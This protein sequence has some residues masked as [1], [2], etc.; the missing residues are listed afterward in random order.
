MKSKILFSVFCIVMLVCTI[1]GAMALEQ[2]PR[3]GITNQESNWLSGTKSTTGYT[4]W[5]DIGVSDTMPLVA[6]LD[7]S[8]ANEVIESRSN[9]VKIF[10]SD[11]TLITSK[12]IS[13]LGNRQV[14]VFNSAH[15]V[16]GK[17]LYLL[18]SGNAQEW[19]FNG[20]NLTHYQ[21]VTAGGTV[22]INDTTGL[23]MMTYGSEHIYGAYNAEV[24]GANVIAIVDFT[25][26]GY[27]D[28]V[29]QDAT[30]NIG[31]PAVG[32]PY[33]DGRLYWMFP[34]SNDTA[35]GVALVDIYGDQAHIEAT[36]LGHTLPLKNPPMFVSRGSGNPDDILLPYNG[37]QHGINSDMQ[38][39]NF[40]YMDTTGY[41]YTTSFGTVNEYEIMGS[42]N[43]GSYAV[44]TP[45][46]LGTGGDIC[47][48]FGW[49]AYTNYLSFE[50]GTLIKCMNPTTLALTYNSTINN[51]ITVG[52]IITYPSRLTATDMNGDG[53][54]DFFLSTEFESGSVGEKC[55]FTGNS[56]PLSC[57]DLAGKDNWIYGVDINN[58]GYR[59]IIE[60]DLTNNLLRIHL[61]NGTAP[62]ATTCSDTDSGSYPT[63]NYYLQGTMTAT[64]ISPRQDYCS[65]NTVYEF[66]CDSPTTYHSLT[67][68]AH[69][70][71]SEGKI[72][73][74]GACVNP[75]ANNSQRFYRDDFDNSFHN[76]T[77][78]DSQY[79]NISYNTTFQ[80]F[81]GY[82]KVSGTTG[83]FLEF[84]NIDNSKTGDVGY[85]KTQY[86][87]QAIDGSNDALV[88][89]TRDSSDTCGARYECIKAGSPT[90][91]TC[92]LW[93][94]GGWVTPTFSSGGGLHT[95]QV[96]FRRETS[97][98]LYTLYY[99]GAGAGS[100]QE[101]ASQCPVIGTPEMIEFG[102]LNTGSSTGFDAN[103]YYVEYSITSQS[104]AVSCTDTDGGIVYE[105]YGTVTYVNT[106]GTVVYNDQCTGV[107]QLKEY[108]CDANNRPVVNYKPCDCVSGRCV[109]YGVC[110]DSDYAGSYPTIQ[111]FTYGEINTSDG[112]HFA[113]VCVPGNSVLEYYCN[114]PNDMNSVGSTTIHCQPGYTCNGGACV[115]QTTCTT[116]PPTYDYPVRW[117]E[118]FDYTDP[119]TAHGWT[120]YP[121]IPG[122]SSYRWNECNRLYYDRSKS[123]DE[124]DY[125]TQAISDNFTYQFSLKPMS[126]ST[127]VDY[128]PYQAPVYVYLKDSTGAEALTLHF[129]DNGY[130]EYTDGNGVTR[131]ITKWGDWSQAMG[132]DY[133]IVMFPSDHKFNFYYTESTSSI[134]YTQGCANCTYNPTAGAIAKFG[135][136]P[137]FTEPTYGFFL[138]T[139]KV[140]IGDTT[141]V[142]LK[143]E[144]PSSDRNCLFY[145]TFSYTDAT[146]NHG[147]YNYITTPTNGYVTLPFD[148]M[149]NFD[150]VITPYSWGSGDGI[151]TYQ[152]NAQFN[153]PVPSD[154][155]IA[156]YAKDSTGSTVLLTSWSDMVYEPF[157][158]PTYRSISAYPWGAW[159]TYSFVINTNKNT[160]SFYID[161]QVKVSNHPLL[162]VSNDI[163]IVGFQV[164]TAGRQMLINSVRVEQGQTFVDGVT[165][166][167]GTGDNG[168]N[169]DYL[170][171]CWS[172]NGT[173]DW[174]CCTADEQASKSMFCPIRVT[175][176]GWLAQ[177]ASFAIG[178]IL[179]VIVLAVILVIFIP[180]L[181]PRPGN[182]GGR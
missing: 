6:D 132:Y 8:G 124:I 152:F 49:F 86:A 63:L 112:H 84:S 162:F 174:S 89:G 71:A 55:I 13:G 142:G 88:M 69:D 147:W 121:F 154:A 27:N 125:A 1:A 82:M 115:P 10:Q 126:F 46:Q 92:G 53:Y 135:F 164:N 137:D 39:I 179:I 37:V 118:T 169:P 45:V 153:K 128:D 60:S 129:A 58:D 31:T 151:V 108:S 54:A 159:D 76:T 40:V 117:Y 72:C 14:T 50:S 19:C 32:N 98:N 116:I 173:Y 107:F 38:T 5:T 56:N 15:C 24:N 160:Y 178:N 28:Y 100:Y 166:S 171:Q 105:T 122:L 61:T 68:T 81:N 161:G 23:G 22:Y 130:I 176:V 167:S 20:V 30:Q 43:A 79:I 66:Y 4:T 87:L 181:V 94:N 11:G 44:S 48:A 36:G 83:S 157:G 114:D 96:S 144:C 146:L 102:R 73:S 65:G 41:I 150:H 33:N 133:I 91:F 52:T 148:S 26:G 77:I 120:G 141:A 51:A 170:R 42:P 104:V 127:D 156:I 25:T 109:D 177:L 172:N 158:L 113:D 143:S 85:V 29:V 99:D 64:G 18:T 78:W 74:S 123:G 136:K 34:Y 62:P 110:S 35:C 149:S 111:P 101:N 3:Y 57:T 119:I 163:G 103:F 93:A 134:D 175:V 17:A 75:P 138:D 9:V 140:T 155:E 131:Q 2:V 168:V 47:Y 165:G 95:A 182:N 21:D 7:G 139:L 145:D 59:D 16:G 12:V 80:V 67:P 70:C 90:T 180:F 106:N 97:Y